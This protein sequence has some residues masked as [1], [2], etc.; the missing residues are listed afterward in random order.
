MEFFRLKML[1]ILLPLLLIFEFKLVCSEENFHLDE[2]QWYFQ[3]ANG[4][5]QGLARVPGD[6]YQDLFAANYISEP[7][8]GENDRLLRWVPR[9]DWIYH[10]TFTIPRNWSKVSF[11]QDS[12]VLFRVII[13]PPLKVRGHI[14]EKNVK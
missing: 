4:S 6:I 12:M 5:I 13:D 10:T 8:F 1:L 14:T 9:M 11:K 2:F 7:L 3:S